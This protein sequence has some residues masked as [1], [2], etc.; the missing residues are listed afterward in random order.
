MVA[1]MDDHEEKR[2]ASMTVLGNFFVA[3]YDEEHD[4]YE[5]V[6][7]RIEAYPLLK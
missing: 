1:K 6:Y 2:A 5:Q 4:F 7:E 3:P